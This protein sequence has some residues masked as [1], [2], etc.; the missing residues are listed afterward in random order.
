MWEKECII[1]INN[2]IQSKNTFNKFNVKIQN[3]MYITAVGKCMQIVN[4]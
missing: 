4:D 2:E 3:Y 1:N